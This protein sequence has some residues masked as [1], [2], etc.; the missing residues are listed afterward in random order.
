MLDLNS[1]SRR[2]HCMCINE[3]ILRK[4][5]VVGNQC[6]II[7]CS[8]GIEVLNKLRKS[9]A[10]KNSS[11]ATRLTVSIQKKMVCQLFEQLYAYFCLYY[12]FP[13]NFV[14]VHPKSTEYFFKLA[15][16]L[17]VKKRKG[18]SGSKF[19]KD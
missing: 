5:N 6:Q 9:L 10:I 14:G 15:S 1:C 13:S 16:N 2:Y 3:D 18:C 11:Q 7:Q 12:T 19:G 17:K 4:K 8:H